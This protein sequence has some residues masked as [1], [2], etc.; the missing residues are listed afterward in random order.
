MDEKEQVP[1]PSEQVIEQEKEQVSEQVSEQEAVQANQLLEDT[2]SIKTGGGVSVIFTKA[3]YIAV[4]VLLVVLAILLTFV[5][6]YAVL[7]TGYEE[8]IDHIKQGYEQD[9]DKIGEF[10]SIAELYS[11]LPKE[12]CNIEMYK[13]LAALDYYYRTSYAGVIDEEQLIY[14]VANGYVV[15]TGDKFGGYYSAD[16]FKTVISGTE[17]QTVGIGVYI[18][19]QT[20]GII[21]ISYVMENGPAHKAGLLPGDKIVSVDGESVSSLGVYGATEKIKGEAGTT[22]TVGVM[23][24]G[25]TEPIVV[26]IVR[27]VVTMETVIYEGHQTEADTAVIRI[28]EFNNTTAEQF[29]TAVKRAISEGRENIVFDLRSNPGGTLTSVV[30]MLDFMLPKGKIATIRQA[31]GLGDEVIYSDDTGEEFVNLNNGMKIAVL[32]NGNTASA[33][34]LFTCALKDYN[35][36]TIVGEKTYGKGCGQSVIPMS[37]GSGL[38]FTTFLYDPPKSGNYNG[39]GIVPDVKAELSEEAQKKNLFDLPHTEDDQLKAAIE[40]L[41]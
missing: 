35:M 39:I 2:E 41:K 21:N 30:E 5:I 36:A 24:S 28:I 32:V 23:R 25:H 37:D 26:K 7:S 19:T 6:T 15:G 27:A 31:N 16:E 1:T 22:V 34:E 10:R 40:A 8:E 18:T 13:K 14:M 33:A 11:T 9:L 3:H 4:T 20:D 12:L 29:K 17:G 38:V